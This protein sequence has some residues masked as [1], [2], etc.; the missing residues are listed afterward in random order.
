MCRE[1]TRESNVEILRELL[2][3][4]FLLKKNDQV[5]IIDLQA[6]VILLLWRMGNGRVQLQEICFPN[7][8]FIQ[9]KMERGLESCGEILVLFVGLADQM[10][11]FGAELEDSLSKLESHFPVYYIWH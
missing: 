3:I 7:L 1:I 10:M 11:S 4:D 6:K 2:E 8:P 9:T 5:K